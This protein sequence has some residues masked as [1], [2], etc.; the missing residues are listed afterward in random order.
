MSG[1]PGMQTF[2]VIG[3][4]LTAYLFM[5]RMEEGSNKADYAML[6]KGIV[7][8]FV[9]FA[10]LLALTVL[11]HS[12][13]LYRL[14]SGP[15]WDRVNFTERQFCRQNWW[16]N[17]LFI[18]NYVNVEQKCLIHS[19]YL[20]ADFWLR[21]LATFCLIRVY[22]K[23]NL[24]FRIL[25]GVFGLSAIAVGYTVYVNKLEAINIFPPE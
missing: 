4:F 14:G 12:T 10:P 2:F 24:K 16:T 23:P 7:E 15:F 9:R 6:L 25:A 5:V 13:W 21:A 3:G 18:D 17:L 11:V 19:W 1:N 8:R 20:A 22:Q